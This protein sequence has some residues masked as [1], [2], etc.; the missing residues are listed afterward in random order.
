MNLRK[1]NSFPVIAIIAVVLA[2]VFAFV[3]GALTGPGLPRA[4][5]TVEPV[6]DY[7]AARPKAEHRPETPIDRPDPIKRP[8]DRETPNKPPVRVP[9]ATPQP[10]LQEGRVDEMVTRERNET[11][12][13]SIV[14][15]IEDPDGNRLPYA[16][17]SLSVRCP[18]VGW[19]VLA[20]TPQQLG[21]GRFL[22]SRLFPGEYRV[23][24]ENPNY[25]QAEEELTLSAGES[26][27]LVRLVLTGAERARVELFIRMPDQSVPQF[28]TI[29]I[30]AGTAQTS[31]NNG[32]FGNYGG[33]V[34]M[35]PGTVHSSMARYAPDA[36]T[37]M[38]PFTVAVGAETRFVLSSMV[39]GRNFGAEVTAK[40]LPGLQ[41]IDVNLIEGDVGR[42]LATDGDPRRLARLELTIIL[43][44]GKPVK[45]TRVNLRQQ[46]TDTAYRDA[47]RSEGNLFVWENILSGRWWLAVEAQ[48]F[49]A[50]YMQLIDLGTIEQQTVDIST[51]RLRVNATMPP[52]SPK[53]D[54]KLLYNVRLRPMGAGNIER[55]FKG[56]LTG[57]QSD[58]IDFF[59]PRGEF[60]VRVDSSGDGLP[61]DV[62]P[63]ERTL[64]MSVGAEAALDFTVR[65]AAKVE[66]QCLSSAGTPVPGVEFLFTTYAAGSVPETERTRVQRGA[67][68]GKCVASGAPSGAVYLMIW[69]GS[70]SWHRPD[71]VFRLDLPAYGHKDLGGLVITP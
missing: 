45:F 15:Q 14:A 8:P 3:L 63:A 19:Q 18:G 71:K 39:E 5:G 2:A 54:G 4:M 35:A 53:G 58:F 33:S 52:G 60:T 28:V 57:K 64:K 41:Q 62:D 47:S 20:V 16:S 69:A 44:G 48:E 26:D 1:L 13:S 6:P 29:Q 67:V 40:G 24:S 66:F 70:T 10:P 17:L 27:R 22:F 31:A 56:N 42:N 68:D 30:L 50:A 55:V 25:R 59:I 51:G 21:D 43:D 46:V 32:R 37:G 36:A 23:R 34:V 7:V 65:A 38:I 49:H 9:D 12:D 61:F 11:A